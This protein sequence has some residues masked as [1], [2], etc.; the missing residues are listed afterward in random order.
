[1]RLSLTV[2]LARLACSLA[3]LIQ[4][5]LAAGGRGAALPANPALPTVWLIGDSTVR[6]GQDDGQGKGEAGQWGWGHTLADF[7]DPAKANLVNRA[8]GGT[9]SR[10]FYAGNWPGVLALV[11]PGDF[12][13][14]Q[15]GHNDN[16]G[17]FTSAGGYR[18]SLNGT[19]DE[20]QTA[21]NRS[22]ASETV[23][24][25]GWY[26][27]QYVAQ[28]RAKGATPIICSLIP[29][30][31]W[32]PDGRIMRH[33]D[34]YFDYAGYAAEVAKTEKTGFIDLNE[35]IA[36]RYDELG[37]DAVVELF[38]KVTPD[39]HTHTNLAVAILNA[40]AVVAGLKAIKDNPVVAFL[41][42]KSTDIAPA[43]LSQPAP[44]VKISPAPAG[45]P[46]AK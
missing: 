18:A 42:A 38:P 22:G 4:P 30:K 29:R 3:F 8:A 28:T 37:H 2:P 24:T 5:A 36:R 34:N 15:F 31:I 13:I 17:V 16:N 12:V 14:M 45:T 7:F 23:H 32:Q 41:S 44:A 6:N 11:K 35:I 1:M 19:G 46:A 27:K 20:T 21:P 33:N 9:S 26:L 39:E 25:F 10:S 43:D 40:R